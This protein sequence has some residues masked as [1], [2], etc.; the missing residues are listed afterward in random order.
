M[1][2]RKR[3]I[4][5]G[6]IAVSSHLELRQKEREREEIKKRNGVI[7]NLPPHIMYRDEF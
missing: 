6:W 2:P 7:Y 5:E 4:H 3:Y 1:D